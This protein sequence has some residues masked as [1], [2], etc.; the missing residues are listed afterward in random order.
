MF[1]EK[2][3]E[4]FKIRAPQAHD[5]I[6][7][8]DH[9]QQGRSTK[10]SSDEFVTE[11]KKID[12]LAGASGELSTHGGKTIESKCGWKVVRNGKVEIYQ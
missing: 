10:L 1:I 12:G 4:P 2:Y 11:L 3:G 8:I 9:I 7:I 5:I 6:K